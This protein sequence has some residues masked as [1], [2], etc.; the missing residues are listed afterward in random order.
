[1]PRPPH[2]ALYS[3]CGFGNFGND[4]TLELVLSH[5]RRQLPQA[6]FTCVVRNPD[7]VAAQLDVPAIGFYPEPR[8]LPKNEPKPLKALRRGAN[9]SVRLAAAFKFLRTI[10]YMIIPGGGRF[11]DFNS[12][13]TEQP[14]WLWKWTRLARLL[15]APV[16]LLSTGAGPVDF[17]LSKWFYRGVA[18]AVSRRSFRDVE[19]QT[20][21]AETL[22]VDTSGDEVT[23]DLVFAF[24]T[25]ANFPPAA[26]PVRTVG[27]GVMEYNNRR[28]AK[29]GADDEY[30]RYLDNI[31]AFSRGVLARGYKVKILIGETCDASAAHDLHARLKE[32]VSEHSDQFELCPA[33]NLHDVL[34]QIAACDLVAATRFHNIVGA[35]LMGCPALSLGYASKN[36][37]V[38]EQFGLSPYCQTIE[39]CDT[40]R[41]L[42]QFD[43][44][45]AAA[46]ALGPGLRT[47]AAILRRDAQTAL[48]QLTQ[49]IEQ[50][51]APVALSAGETTLAPPVA[52]RSQAH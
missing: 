8:F 12:L 30:G 47:Q 2:I 40:D 27:V 52:R 1:M 39:T 13:A 19:S 50:T 26:A 38:M 34:A 16:E 20:Y 51:L 46:G 43:A 21:V 11:D 18:R 3:Q 37:R 42:A 25:P 4:A 33:A 6:Q 5:L 36:L 23:P 48:D 22:G 35:L 45:C 28:G 32:T 14:Y 31:A 29:G 24:P 7:V 49:R 41:L 44:L 10:D 9:E 15:G 17:E